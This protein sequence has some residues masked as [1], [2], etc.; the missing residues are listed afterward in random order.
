M[1]EISAVVCTYNRADDLSDC[2]AGLLRQSLPERQYEVIVID[3]NSTD[4]TRDLVKGLRT[5]NRN[6]RYF[7][8]TKQGLAPA[9]NRALREAASDIVAFTDDDAIPS[10]TWLSDLHRRFTSMPAEVAAVGGDVEAV[11]EI[12]RPAWLNDHLLHPLSA[13]LNWSAG[14]R[15][16]RAGEWLVEV[17]SAYRKSALLRYGGFPE[18]LGR[19]GVNL[20]SGEN[21]INLLLSAN[22]Y[23]FYYDPHIKVRHKIPAGRLSKSWFRRRYFWQGVTNYYVKKY[24]F[25][26][27]ESR[28]DEDREYENLR[29]EMDWITVP[30]PTTGAQW[31][32]L[33]E[34][35][36]D[37]DFEESLRRIEGLGYLLAAQA[38][39][40]GR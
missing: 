12:E 22:G 36:D 33:F 27:L 16:L 8:E 35:G 5:K 23:G 24:V 2:L 17:N 4:S 28:G 34:E 37:N 19:I 21:A 18:D 3:N 11:W 9:R 38:I 31:A 30:V 39:I 14:P 32:E 26:C 25:S 6:L 20:L 15:F 13:G 7:V 10:R 1:V 40:L 29:R